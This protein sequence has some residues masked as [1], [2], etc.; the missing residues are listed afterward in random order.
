MEF[1]RTERSIHINQKGYVDELLK[2][3]EMSDCKPVRASIDVDI[4]LNKPEDH[5]ES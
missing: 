1:H 4:K 3:Y 5:I 2:K